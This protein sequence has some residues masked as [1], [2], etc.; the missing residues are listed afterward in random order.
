M[1]ELDLPSPL[2]RKAKHRLAII[3]HVEGVTGNVAQ[4][5][6]SL[7]NRAWAALHSWNADTATR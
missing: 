4:E 1:S 5:A 3:Q 7:L 6:G 2:D